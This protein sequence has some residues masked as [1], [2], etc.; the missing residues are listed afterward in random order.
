MN[1][2]DGRIGRRFGDY[3]ILSV[4]GA[5]GF[6]TVYE[7]RQRMQLGSLR[8]GPRVAIKVLKRLADTEAYERNRHD[9]I[10][11]AERGI[12]SEHPLI[13]K[14][15]AAGVSEREEPY[16]VM[17]YIHGVTG[18]QLIE[19]V[20]VMRRQLPVSAVM[21]IGQRAAEALLHAHGDLQISHRDVKPS[22][23][24]IGR[25]GHFKLLDLGISRSLFDP[26]HSE[27]VV[28]GSIDYMAPE[29]F[30][31]SGGNESVDTFQVAALVQELLTAKRF[32]GEG[33]TDEQRLNASVRGW[34][35]PLVRDD[36]PSRLRELLAAMLSG[37]PADRPDLTTVMH[38]FGAFLDGFNELRMSSLVI[39]LF[40]NLR[41]S[42]IV[43]VQA[44][45][46]GGANVEV[47]AWALARGE[48]SIDKISPE[49]LTVVIDR[50]K[51]IAKERALAVQAEPQAT[52][53]DVAQP[54]RPVRPAMVDAPVRVP[55]PR[56]RASNA[57]RPRPPTEPDFVPPPPPT[58][59]LEDVP[60][61][62]TFGG[63]ERA[64]ESAPQGSVTPVPVANEVLW[65]PLEGDAS[66]SVVVMYRRLMTWFRS[67]AGRQ[68][69]TD[70]RTQVLPPLNASYID[71]D[72]VQAMVPMAR[73]EK[74][75][76]EYLV[77][78]QPIRAKP[79]RRVGVAL[80]VC[81]SAASVASLV[82]LMWVGLGMRDL[83]DAPVA[84]VEP[85]A[86]PKLEPA[87][88]ESTHTATEGTCLA[89]CASPDAVAPSRE[90]LDPPAALVP[91]PV[92]V[93]AEPPVHDAMTEDT[94]NTPT[95]TST[96]K[97]SEDTRPIVAV[98][99]GPFMGKYLELRGLRDKNERRI[100]L[101]DGK[102]SID[103]R[104][105]VYSVRWKTE[106]SEPW[107]GPKRLVVKKG[108]QRVVFAENDLAVR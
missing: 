60:V 78:V 95:S 108:T 93:D 61:P 13:A 83:D 87:P 5:G 90:D 51:G 63:T 18:A 65:H 15:W 55:T 45:G 27:K 9:F 26:L 79:R 39:S 2:E 16:I 102:K 8:T 49:L 105:G 71:G 10:R 42:G 20:R 37:E 33:M 23:V 24:M 99:F 64:P 34:V 25:S 47:L 29:Q 96:A 32:R 72:V 40:P 31:T 94:D 75:V 101:E 58:E 30:T 85:A 98:E 19:R 11:E 97:K 56:A 62:R 77:D 14:V 53:S 41:E 28:K 91:P 6:A 38:E 92:I 44:P 50:A 107:R 104:A 59:V 36:V 48:L 17:E 67:P 73:T 84:S 21:L 81:G 68:M 46:P 100:K 57:K 106:V 7:G 74:Y 88:S 3:E 54:P 82:G 86:E 12:L 89:P 4:I 35:P 43:Q 70:E 80:A 66:P 76:T 69:L 103:V 22:N 52:A 1:A